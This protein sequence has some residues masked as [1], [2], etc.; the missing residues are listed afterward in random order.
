MGVEAD[1]RL[2]EAI[3]AVPGGPV[4][5]GGV[6]VGWAVIGFGIFGAITIGRRINYS[7]AIWFLGGLLVHDFLVAPIVFTVGKALR[8]VVAG[9]YRAAITAALV[10]SAF[11]VVVSIPFLGRFGMRADNAT[12]LP[13]NYTTGLLVMLAIVWTF[14]AATI[15]WTRWAWRRER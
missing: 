1:R 14:T 12:V 2:N 5:W 9:R 15:V 11:F 8:R 4:F 13:R 7:F 3:E 10:V 6:L